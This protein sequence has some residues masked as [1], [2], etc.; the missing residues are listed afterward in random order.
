MDYCQ[1][2]RQRSSKPKERVIAPERKNQE[3]LEW[4]CRDD[5]GSLLRLD[6]FGKR[7]CAAEKQAHRCGPSNGGSHALS[8]TSAGINFHCWGA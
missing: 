3:E 5:E 8:R 2:G 1:S 4:N 6:F 7:G